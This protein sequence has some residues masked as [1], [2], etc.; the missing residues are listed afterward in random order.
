MIVGVK[1]GKSGNSTT[2]KLGVTDLDKQNFRTSLFILAFL[3]IPII[4]IIIGATIARLKHMGKLKK[5]KLAG[6]GGALVDKAKQ[7]D[8]GKWMS[9]TATSKNRKGF[10][11]LRQDSEDEEAE[12]LTKEA[13]SSSSNGGIDNSDYEES[14]S[15]AEINLPQITK[16]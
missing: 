3:V 11:R 4:L 6:L 5:L 7:K 10:T 9:R 16:A 12:Q 1:G 2:S 15:E 8:L 13:K 14:N